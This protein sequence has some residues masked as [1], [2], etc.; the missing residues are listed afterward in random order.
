MISQ[1]LPEKGHPRSVDL[2]NKLICQ[3][4]KAGQIEEAF[5]IFEIMGDEGCNP[6]S[7]TYNIVIDLIGTVGKV[8]LALQLF[9]QMK[10][11]GFE[12]DIQTYSIMVGLLVH[13]GRSVLKFKVCQEMVSNHIEPQEGV[14][15]ILREAHGDGSDGSEDYREL[16]STHQDMLKGVGS[17]SIVK[18]AP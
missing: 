7:G 1:E 2:Y 4:G 12:P 3:L 6:D 10:E 9:Q 14:L 18:H 16:M 5:K 11:K 17:A 13:A 8:D 15:R